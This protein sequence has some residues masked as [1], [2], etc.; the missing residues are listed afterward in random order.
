MP[1][2]TGPRLIE[3]KVIRVQRWCCVHANS[4]TTVVAGFARIQLYSAIVMSLADDSKTLYT[5]NF[6]EA[7]SGW[8]G[9]AA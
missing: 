3:A 1:D 6:R 5:R 8:N 2:D 4:V 9:L 7:F